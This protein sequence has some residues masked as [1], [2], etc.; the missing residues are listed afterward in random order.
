MDTQERLQKILIKVGQMQADLSK[1]RRENDALRKANKFLKL[2]AE[3]G[4]SANMEKAYTTKEEDC[5]ISKSELAAVKKDVKGYIEEIDN[6][7]SWLKQL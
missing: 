2:E 7:I 6:S 4:G 1:L 3:H 5:G